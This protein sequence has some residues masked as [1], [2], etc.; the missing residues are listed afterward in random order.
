MSYPAGPTG[1]ATPGDATPSGESAATADERLP[2]LL[3]AATAVLGVVVFLLGFAPY[4]TFHAMSGMGGASSS[5]FELGS[6]TALLGFLLLGGVAAGLSLLPKQ[7]LRGVAAAAA[8]VGFVTLLVQSLNLGEG[9]KLAGA[10]YATLVIA[11]LEAAVAI[12]AFV[13]GTGLVTLPAKTTQRGYAPFQQGGGGYGSGYG[14]QGYGAPSYGG[15][16]GYGQQP[17]YGQQGQPG[18]GQQGQPYGRPQGYPQSGGYGAQPSP[19][20][21][22]QPSHGQGAQPSH[23]QPQYPRQEGYGQQYGAAAS[24]GYPGQ[25]PSYPAGESA[26]KDTSAGPTQAIPTQDSGTEAGGDATQAFR[27]S[28]DEKN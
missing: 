25:W 26:G 23:G 24:G 16:Q 13:L 4:V 7:D 9:V 19:G 1:G 15:Q 8:A 10:A 2:R 3:L 17:G 20:Q 18:Y 14:Q 6:V 5:I 22:A 21:G 11:F 27:P 28:D 12:A